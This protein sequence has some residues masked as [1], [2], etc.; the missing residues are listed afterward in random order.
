MGY[1]DVLDTGNIFA[2]D[3]ERENAFESGLTNGFVC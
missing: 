1:K 2:G 3:R